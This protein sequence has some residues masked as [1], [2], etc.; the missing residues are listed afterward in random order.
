MWVFQNYAFKN[1]L[2]NLVS[3][4]ADE[5]MLDISELLKNKF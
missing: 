4:K 3:T 5:E 1:D 2:T